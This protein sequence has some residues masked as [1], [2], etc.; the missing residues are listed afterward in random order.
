MT[1]RALVAAVA[2][3]AACTAPR[4]ASDV[5][6][7]LAAFVPLSG[8][9][10]P[11]GRE[12]VDALRL[13][14][15][16][17][18]AAG[19]VRGRPVEVVVRDVGPEDARARWD[20][21]RRERPFELALAASSA[22]ALELAPRAHA[23]GVFLLSDAADARV[24]ELCPTSLRHCPDARS[25]CDAVAEDALVA[26]GAGSLALLHV[27]NA[28]GRAYPDVLVAAVRA[29]GG[30][31]A[32]IASHPPD[33]VPRGTLTSLLAASPGAVFCVGY[34][35]PLVEALR[36]LR[37]LGFDGRLYAAP[38]VA[39]PGT[40]DVAPEALEG[41]LFPDV[42]LD[43]ELEDPLLAAR[44][45]SFVEAWR[46]ATGR[47]PTPLAA[48]T[49]DAA[50]LVLLAAATVEPGDARALRAAV[51]SLARP[52]AGWASGATG[53]LAVREDGSLAFRLSIHELRQGRAVPAGA[54]VGPADG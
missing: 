27:D 23:D 13:A 39:Y 50:R 15:D 20:E 42:R 28:Y 32:A 35:P 31:V 44:R 52:F 4:A 2:L 47:E 40:L 1:R 33:A 53:R 6:L 41:V 19:G 21:L 5:P 49:Y 37:V 9:F 14:A 38:S 12:Q 36:G 45:A 29:R 18:D 17:V 24:A 46:A 30:R 22:V 16:A 26:H 25:E 48:T 7:V 11:F 34:G 51:G 10:A 8:D 3:G 54:R 43:A